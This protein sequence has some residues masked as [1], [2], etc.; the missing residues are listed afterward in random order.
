MSAE[1]SL[2]VLLVEDDLEDAD[3]FRRHAADSTSYR[4]E[5]DHVTTSE[6]ARRRLSEG[7]YDLVFL[8]LRLGEPLT[9]VEVL[10]RFAAGGLES[11]VIVLTGAGDERT[12]VEMMKAGATDYLVKDAFN[13][14]AM[15]RSIRYALEQQRLTSERQRAEEALRQSEER[16]RLVTEESVTYIV[17]IQEGCLCYVNPRVVKET[18]YN[19]EELL[20]KS[21]LDFLYS[22]DRPKAEQLLERVFAGETVEQAE[23][24]VHRRD[25][26]T[27]WARVNGTRIDYRGRPAALLN[28][29]DITQE[30][31]LE[32]QLLQTE[33]LTAIG[34]L[35]SG[36]AHE[37]NNPLTAVLGYAQL[38]Q[39]L[40]VEGELAQY[41]EQIAQ[42]AVRASAIV[43]N[44]LTFAR[45]KEPEREPLDTNA[46]IRSAVD[47]REYDLRVSNV[48][49]V[50][51]FAQELPTVM[52]DF[53]QLQQVILNLINNADS[54]IRQHSRSGT[55][56]LR[57]STFSKQDKPW[58]RLEVM[59]DGPGI[60]ETYLGRIFDPFFTTKEPG[61]GT[62]LGLSVSYGIVTAHQGSIYAEIRPEGGA[63]FVVE[64][65]AT[66]M[67]RSRPS[68]PL[69]VPTVA[70][71]R[72]LV[73]EDEQAVA[74]MLERLLTVDGHYVI[75]ASDGAQAL[76][77]LGKER[78]DQIIIDF[79]MPGMSGLQLYQRLSAHFPEVAER[80]VFV[81]G[82]V[83]SADTL[84]FLEEVEAPV[85][86]KPFTI[87]EARRVFYQKLREVQL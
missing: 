38:A 72:L 58:V 34:E 63:R 48:Q 54:A 41:L 6:Q 50:L 51:Q 61:R 24:R 15:E 57:T 53:Q 18:G 71:A 8:D 3:I 2:R 14:E 47:L 33:K 19:S 59:D 62:G 31:H 45:Q 67:S 55:I 20:G 40:P 23:I 46:I 73:V 43:G 36:V 28:A 77:H 35:I 4:V 26:E 29:V 79:K 70:P 66:R 69:T 85:L 5:V 11:P 37:L 32:R 27:I 80:V 68:S 86:A 83:L 49:V 9:G 21:L 52:A 12:A 76:A 42:Q 65:P 17:I 22:Q 81:T 30:K 44:L 1:T 74:S 16:Y 84:T 56:I 87:E 10:E 60:P 64:L 7:R 75:L 39:S 78:F 13:R 25:G 82:D